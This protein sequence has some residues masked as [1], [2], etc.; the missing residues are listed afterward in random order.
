MILLRRIIISAH[1]SRGVSPLQM[2]IFLIISRCCVFENHWTITQG[3]A[4]M[5]IICISIHWVIDHYILIY[6]NIALCPIQDDPMLQ[7]L[8]NLPYKEQ[9]GDGRGFLTVPRNIHNKDIEFGI[10]LIWFKGIIIAL[11]WCLF[12]VLFMRFGLIYSR[13]YSFD[14]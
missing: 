5:F 2:N 4:F 7:P 12:F 1:N 6:T 11:Y 14:K 3:F 13:P 8:N 9:N 10:F